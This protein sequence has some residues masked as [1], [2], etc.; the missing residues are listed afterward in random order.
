MPSVVGHALPMIATSHSVLS[1]E[2][3]AGLAAAEDLRVEQR[4]AW[5][6]QAFHRQSPHKRVPMSPS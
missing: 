6:L 2:T 1:A 3:E 4:M 5:R